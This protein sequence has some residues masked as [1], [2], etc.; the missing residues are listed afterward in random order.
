MEHHQ[1]NTMIVL[2]CSKLPAGLEHKLV[3]ASESHLRV[4]MGA[5]VKCE[6]HCAPP[7]FLPV[8]TGDVVDPKGVADVLLPFLLVFAETRQDVNLVELRVNG[9]SLSKTGHRHC[10]K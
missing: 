6:R 5:F 2:S 9:G 3:D 10:H 8:V 1:S 4:K 7:G